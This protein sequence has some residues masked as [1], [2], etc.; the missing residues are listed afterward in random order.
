MIDD[1][2]I[3]G[4]LAAMGLALVSVA[5][6]ARW[7]P[8]PIAHTVGIVL[9]SAGVGLLTARTFHAQLHPLAILSHAAALLTLAWATLAAALRR[10]AIRTDPPAPAT[11][12]SPERLLWIAAAC[13]GLTTAAT[14]FGSLWAATMERIS[15]LWMLTIPHAPLS[16]TG[17]FDL[18]TLVVVLCI[19]L[20]ALRDTRLF[21]AL[22]ATL[23]LAGWYATLMLPAWRFLHHPDQLVVQPVPTAWAVFLAL[24]LTALGAAFLAIRGWAEFRWLRPQ[25]AEDLWHLTVPMPPWP[26]L[27][28]CIAVTAAAVFVITCMHLRHPGSAVAAMAMAIQ[29]FWLA[30]RRWSENLANAGL[31]L[32]SL[33]IAATTTALVPL[34]EAELAQQFP[35]LFAGLLIG[36][37]LMTWLWHWLAGVWAQQ[38]LDGQP[39]TTTGRLVAPAKRFGF[40]L[41]VVGTAI[42]AQLAVWPTIP[43]A[44]VAPHLATAR[45]LGTA[46]LLLFIAALADSARRTRKTTLG[47][48]T[49]INVAILALYWAVRLEPGPPRAFLA[50]HGPAL[51]G[52]LCTLAAL[53]LP[54]APPPSWR[55]LLQPLHITTVVALVP[56]AALVAVRYPPWAGLTLALLFLTAAAWAILVR[57]VRFR[58]TR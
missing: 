28:E 35:A 42:G 2:Q 20:V 26:G 52:L 32:S 12:A 37:A 15:G 24:Y 31:A 6:P 21:A 58:L 9:A 53:T 8:P 56:A 45:F 54:L 38:L 7:C 5:A 18:F 55:A 40:V 27:R 39:W 34:P 4:A 44:Y 14:L 23:A 22:Y 16:P 43:W 17:L 48:L 51:A 50:A 46:A 47:W 33:S 41:G 19:A 29:C 3:I 57:G 13:F 11:P 10:T 30:H 25:A 36:I 49:L 1:P